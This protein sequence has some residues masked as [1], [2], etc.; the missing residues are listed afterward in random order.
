MC[1][2]NRQIYRS[3]ILGSPQA[4]ESP[5]SAIP[6]RNTKRLLLRPG[7]KTDF[8]I[9]QCR[10]D[11]ELTL[12]IPGKQFTPA[13]SKVFEHTCSIKSNRQIYIVWKNRKKNPRNK[14]PP[15]N[16]T[17][18]Q[19]QGEVKKANVTNLLTTPKDAIRENALTMMQNVLCMVAPTQGDSA[20]KI[21]MER[22]FVH[23]VTAPQHPTP[24]IDDQQGQQVMLIIAIKANTKHQ[25]IKIP[26]LPTKSCTLLWHQLQSLNP[27]RMRVPLEIKIK[28][29]TM[30]IISM[31][32]INWMKKQRMRIQ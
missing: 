27:R 20:T 12:S 1:T 15:V 11:G 32:V 9:S 8:F 22:T 2:E 18:I 4:N 7:V 19:I 30:S 5:H 10:L 25:V 17:A 6:Q 16:K 14:E 26:P 24:T 29:D 13:P 23:V 28:A 31:N 3:K 21:N